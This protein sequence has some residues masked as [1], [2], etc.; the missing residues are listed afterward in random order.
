[1]RFDFGDLLIVV[2]V[3]LVIGG[4]YLLSL[5]AALIVGGGVC[6]GAGILRGMRRT[7]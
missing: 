6:V 2:G 1:M 7:A 3:G 4:I 5:P